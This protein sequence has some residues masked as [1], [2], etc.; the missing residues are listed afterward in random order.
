MKTI[1]IVV[2]NLHNGGAERMAA[3]MSR[4]LSAYFKVVLVVFDSSGDIYPFGGTKID[5]EVPPLGEA[6]PGERIKNTLLRVSKL[7]EL[8]KKY[9]VAATIS[10][11]EGANLANILSGGSGKTFCLYHSLP[12]GEFK[13]DFLHR[14]FFRFCA[15]H[16]DGFY[17]VSE[18]A[19][20][21]M[22]KN[23]H[24]PAGKVGVMYNF[25]DID[26]IHRDMKEPLDTA[27]WAFCSSHKRLIISLGRL[28][29]LKAQY[30]LFRILKSMREDG[31]EAGLILLGEGPERANLSKIARR[32]GLMQ[33]IYM[34]GEVRN[35]FPYLR[36]SDA[37]ALCSDYE[38]LPM[39]L[40]ESM[41]C[42]CPVVSCNM[43]SGVKEILGENNEYGILTPAFE[44]VLPEDMPDQDRVTRALLDEAE[45]A[46][47]EMCHA[48][49]NLL[50]HEET[51]KKYLDACEEG[52]ERF[53]ARTATQKWL[54]VLG[55]SV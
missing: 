8:K 39:V 32:M 6:S 17:C 45:D 3:N 12:S 47:L 38:S 37:F 21:D 49:E 30:R 18:R 11:M 22:R 50:A 41:A 44:N 2:Q 27:A 53:S 24:V 1:A 48:L 13:P 9:R 16:S 19:A 46:E 40:L 4:A 25:L 35:P 10:H 20:E 5:L 36:A 54:T 42:G 14:Q 33:H 28:I 52:A 55:E 23:F 7:R 26:Q 34:P 43:P 31:L 15:G 51:R 29:P